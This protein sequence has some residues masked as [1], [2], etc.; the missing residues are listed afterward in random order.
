MLTAENFKD[1]TREEQE[2]YLIAST[3]KE[4]LEAWGGSF[5]MANI[6]LDGGGLTL[7]LSTS[8]GLEKIA[9]VEYSLLPLSATEQTD[10][11]IS[12]V[13]NRTGASLFTT[14]NPNTLSQYDLL[15]IPVGLRASSAGNKTVW[16]ITMQLFVDD[17]NTPIKT[18]SARIPY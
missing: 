17:S 14:Y 6:S 11:Q 5:G 7:N 16:L 4:G 10:S 13:V 15:T 9:R 18:Y 12:G 1:M 2:K 3:R 8:Y